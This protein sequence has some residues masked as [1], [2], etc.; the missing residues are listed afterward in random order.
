MRARGGM[1]RNPANDARYQFG[2][3]GDHG[4]TTEVTPI[5][6][7]RRRY[8]L[9]DVPE[10]LLMFHPHRKTFRA[11]GSAWKTRRPGRPK[12]KVTA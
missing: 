8:V 4:T 6:P 5:D 9:D 2:G 7:N 1:S 3:S 12:K 11:G 10:H